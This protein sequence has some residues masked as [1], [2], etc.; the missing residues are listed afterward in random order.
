[1]ILKPIDENWTCPAPDSDIDGVFK[2]IFL[3]NEMEFVQT[4]AAGSQINSDPYKFFAINRVLLIRPISKNPNNRY[5]SAN[6]DC[7]LTIAKPTDSSQEVETV[8]VN[9]QFDEITK[10]FLN[11]SFANTLKSY[12]QCCDYK[13]VITQIRPIWNSTVA[14][15]RIN[16]SG[17]EI[18][19]SVE[20]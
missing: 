8:S 10:E 19:L 12:F 17:V 7:L 6:Y 13:I 3:F 20:I 11:I 4:D 1:M 16:H 5:S 2:N 18:N 15:K 9:G 14:A